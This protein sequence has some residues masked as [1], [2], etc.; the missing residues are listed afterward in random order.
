M[1]PYWSCALGEILLGMVVRSKS[2]CSAIVMLYSDMALASLKLKGDGSKPRCQG[3]EM[4]WDLDRTPH[5]L[6]K[7]VGERLAY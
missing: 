7:R 4:P 5:P 1:D 3:N 2:N 6:G